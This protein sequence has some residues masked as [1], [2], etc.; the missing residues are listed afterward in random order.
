MELRSVIA[1]VGTAA[2]VLLGLAGAAAI[3]VPALAG[4]SAH[5]E[6]VVDLPEPGDVPDGP[7]E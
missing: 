2:V 1:V 6:D 3:A 4:P 5:T 7:G